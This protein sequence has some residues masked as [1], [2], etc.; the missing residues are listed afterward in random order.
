MLRSFILLMIISFIL[1]GCMQL[2]FAKDISEAEGALI[3]D[4]YK[5][6]ISQI[7]SVNF[8]SG[9]MNGGNSWVVIYS[10]PRDSFGGTTYVV[11]HKKTK[12]VVAD[13][14]YQ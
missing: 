10:P 2:P 13:F 6:N 3:A 11:V 12:E 9:V 1:M 4:N 5:K 14:G 7:R 8:R